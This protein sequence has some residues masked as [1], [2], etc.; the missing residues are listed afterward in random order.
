MTYRS[1]W[2][3]P[4]KPRSDGEVSV[5]EAGMVVLLFF[6]GGGKHRCPQLE[7]FYSKRRSIRE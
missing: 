5:P 3:S 7:E 4:T 1:P 6:G 2:R